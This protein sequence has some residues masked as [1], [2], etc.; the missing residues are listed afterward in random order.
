VADG[1][2]PID[3][4]LKGCVVGKHTVDGCPT[5]VQPKGMWP[6]GMCFMDV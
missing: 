2:V 1:L 6:I 4:Q 3:V 5:D